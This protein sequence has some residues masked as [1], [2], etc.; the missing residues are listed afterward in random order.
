[1]YGIYLRPQLYLTITSVQGLPLCSVA[2]SSGK[3]ASSVLCSG[4]TEAQGRFW[5]LMQCP[6]KWLQRLCPNPR[7]GTQL[8]SS[9]NPSSLPPLPR[10]QLEGL[11]Q[12]SSR[13]MS[14]SCEGTQSGRIVPSSAAGW[15][16]ESS[17]FAHPALLSSHAWHAGGTHSPAGSFAGVMLSA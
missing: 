10:A 15:V 16:W 17:D 12:L 14:T 5:G 11:A 9:P 3:K 6:W 4:E 13:E 2:G 1:M 8:P 7:A